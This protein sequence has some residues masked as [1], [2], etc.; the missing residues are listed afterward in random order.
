MDIDLDEWE[1]LPDTRHTF[2][3]FSL[4]NEEGFLFSKDADSDYFSNDRNK[5]LVEEKEVCKDIVMVQPPLQVP[6][7]VADH[8]DLAPI[9]LF[10][11]F[12]DE[13]FVDMKIESPMPPVEPEQMKLNSEEEDK[14]YKDEKN[15]EKEIIEYV[16]PEVKDKQ[17]GLGI[18]RW[19]LGRGVGALCSIGV[20]TATL[21]IFIL[22]GRQLQKHQNKNQKIQFQIYTDEKVHIF[23]QLILLIQ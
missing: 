17:F 16:E 8:S 4:E 20:A 15:S 9:I 11:N 10:K 19:R 21:C 14:L 3:D 2:I 18:W 7:I 6:V 5:R 23:F 13:K 1:L 12:K 22:G